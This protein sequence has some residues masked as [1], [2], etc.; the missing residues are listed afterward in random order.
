MKLQKNGIATIGLIFITVLAAFQYV[1]LQ[2]VPD[3]VSTFAFVCVTNVIGLLILSIV[4]VKKLK[5]ITKRTLLKGALFAVELIGFNFFL[6]L[7]SRHLDAVIISSLVSLYFVFITPILLLWFCQALRCRGLIRMM[8]P[9]KKGRPANMIQE[10][11]ASVVNMND[12]EVCSVVDNDILC[13]YKTKSIYQLN[14]KRR[15]QIALELIHDCHINAIQAARCVAIPVSML[16]DEY[17]PR[18]LRAY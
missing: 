15:C 9:T 10:S 14:D 7:G 11:L 3:T 17:R 2:N 12:M 18:K 13:R 5:A 16:P 6:L 4:R 1:F 8:K